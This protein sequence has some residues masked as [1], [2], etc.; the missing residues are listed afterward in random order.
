[1][2]H[3]DIGEKLIG[4][5]ISMRDGIVSSQA[6]AN[7][8]EFGQQY[9]GQIVNIP[10]ESGIIG[11]AGLF[12]DESRFGESFCHEYL[13]HHSTAYLQLYLHFFSH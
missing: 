12:S 8:G 1:M 9:D 13:V 2:T 4:S 7:Q 11:Y 10:L 3:D 5:R 6:M